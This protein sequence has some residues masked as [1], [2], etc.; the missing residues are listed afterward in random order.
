MT[1]W[2]KGSELNE[3]AKQEALAKFVHRFTKQRRP[4]WASANLN[5]TAQFADDQD[6]LANTHFAVTKRG[7]LDARFHHCD[8][9]PT[10]PDGKGVWGQKGKDW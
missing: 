10:W 1:A 2:I 9:K 3:T 4:Q 7:T 6:W 8:S 5:Y